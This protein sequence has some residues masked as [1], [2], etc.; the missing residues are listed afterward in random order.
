M[1]T[2]ETFKRIRNKIEKE[3]I[4]ILQCHGVP[5]SGKSQIIRKLAKDFPFGNNSNKT[6]F[7]IK[8]H[9]QCKDSDH[10]LRNEL[11]VLVEKLTEHPFIRKLEINQSIVDNLEENET[12]PL[13]DFLI[14]VDVPVLLIV[15][16]P[17]DRQIT[18]LKN[19]CANL[20][21]HAENPKPHL[22]IIHLYISS[23][24]N[25]VLVEEQNVPCYRLEKVEGFSKQEA[26]DHLSLKEI[27][28]DTDDKL[29]VFQF[30]SGLPL[31][32]NAA[33]TFCSKADI[34]YQEYLELMKDVDYD[35]INKENDAVMKE[36]GSSAPHVFEALVVPFSPRDKDEKS[37][38][39][40]WK[41]LC[42][43]SYFHYDRIPR[44]VFKQCCHL[45][46]EK[47]VK[48]SVLSNKVEVGTLVSDLLDH[49]MCTKTDEQ[50]ITFHEVVLHAFRLNH[51]S[52]VED[53]SNTLKKS[54]EIM[55]SLISK[56]LRK[57]E[58]STK[59]FKLRRH[60]QTLLDHVENNQQIFEDKDDGH[61]LR[62]LTSYLHETTAAIML[63][64]SPS[65]YWNECGEHFERALNVMFS[66]DICEYSKLP[67]DDQ[68]VDQIAHKIIKVFQSKESLPSDEFSIKYA[69]KLKLS[70][71]D[72]R[73]ELE[74]LKSRTTNSQCFAELEKLLSEKG[75]TEDIIEKL[76]K[77][78]LFLSNEKY[79]SVFYAERF[80]SILYSWSRLVLYGDPDD[81]N[82]IKKRCSWM[83]KLSHEI[84]IKCKKSFGV[85]LLVEHLSIKGGRIP[86]LLKVKESPEKELEEALRVCEEYLQSEEIPSMFE[87]G[88]L[89]EVYGPSTNDTRITLLRY[90]VRINARIL[91]G[92]N[93]ELA[94]KRCEEL[95]ELSVAHAKTIRISIQ[96][97]IYCAKY[98][99]ARGDF[100][101]AMK[102]F[103]KFFELES[104]CDSRFHVRSWA[105][106]NY[107]RA[108]IKFQCSP[109]EHMKRAFVKCENVLTERDEVKKSVK[110]HLIICKND[111]DKKLQELGMRKRKLVEETEE[112][113][114]AQKQE[115]I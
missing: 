39:L 69:S 30:F 35:I 92:P 113:V 75:P 20:K 98:Y 66:R 43:L 111:L 91:R 59:M 115:Q 80:A 48:K 2:T 5:G 12:K 24:K 95:F 73:D 8:W 38:V 63:G 78:D 51:F 54:I 47:R 108:V 72:Q 83:S 74:F 93:F 41:I 16:D 96:C 37:T 3:I 86:I 23:R 77:C 67:N 70:F 58:H 11:V 53:N 19:L 18:L 61:L 40:P 9:I 87:N 1:V 114:V 71:E 103:E 50:E 45:L 36:F 79:R 101:R 68:S 7:L 55:C 6:D 32:L 89:K 22:N 88:L 94:D 27:E 99:A 105:I 57:T 42:C 26:L 81:V 34:N 13:V 107:A 14:K 64:E 56:D 106:Y 112:R 84:S 4:T 109:P 104:S 15:E 28:N 33:K 65:L 102:C 82:K 76:Q 60:L 52:V 29:A 21:S 97:F 90:I 25:T 85:A 62:A 44:Y 17:P 49:S 100:D 31:G 46:R 110:D 10:D